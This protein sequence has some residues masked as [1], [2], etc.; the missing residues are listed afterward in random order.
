MSRTLFI[1]A[2][3]Y[4]GGTV[5]SQLLAS[6]DASI[7][8]LSIDV[9][10][11]EKRQ[12]LELDAKY[13][14]RIT[15]IEWS[16]LEDTTFIENTV[17]NYDIVINTGCGFIPTGAIAIVRG[18]ARR[19]EAGLVPCMLHISGCTNLAEQPPSPMRE[20]SDE[21]DQA[22]ILEHMKA[23]EK[24]EKYAQRTTEIGILEAA[25]AAG[26]RAISVN[27]PCIFG[28]GTGLF[29]NQGL[30]I[31]LIMEYVETHGYG[32]RLND[33]ANFD[34]VHILDLADLFVLL[35]RT[36]L[37]RGDQCITYFSTR[38]S[39][40]M[41]AAVG[42]MLIQDINQKCLDV[43][44]EKR[45]LPRNGTPKEKEIRLVPLQEIADTLTAGRAD[46]AKRGWGGHKSTKADLARKLG[47]EPK[48]LEQDWNCAFYDALTTS[49]DRND[50]ENDT[51]KS[52]IGMA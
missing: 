50:K 6:T 19:V 51:M 38:T 12:S 37:E 29:R 3:G 2:T 17:S 9:L 14:S 8:N 52:C 36:I 7:N 20:W 48:R 24:E 34:W 44:F 40:I 35:V 43:L 27:A 22:E 1:G 21:E 15:I 26:V 13:G 4:I 45:I 11:R 30:V 32:F 5:L 28:K 33:T 46:V 18:L 41:F 49:D 39:S 16:G 23:L 25:A 42:R 10:V 31:P 47:W